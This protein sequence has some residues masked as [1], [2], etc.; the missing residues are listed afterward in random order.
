MEKI[1][2]VL[3]I[4]QVIN[5]KVV[6]YESTINSTKTGALMATEEIGSEANEVLIVAC[7]NTKNKIVA[8]HR[9][10]VGSI[11]SS[12][13]HPREIF[14]AAILN[15]ATRIMMFHNHPSGDTEPSQADISITERI[16]EAG[17]LLGIDL[18]DHI[19][20]SDNPKNYTSLRGYGVF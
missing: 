12:V 6:G 16:L 20:V 18:L 19:I 2:E 11:N 8:L 7:L 13:A 17:N 10:S 1:Y 5:E 3:S 4:K 9:V 15:N 14:K